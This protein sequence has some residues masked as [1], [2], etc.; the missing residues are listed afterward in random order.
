MIKGNKSVSGSWNFGPRSDEVRSVSDVTQEAIA[1][2][3]SGSV[4]LDNNRDHPHEATLLQLDCSKAQA[5]LNWSPQWDFVTTMHETVTWYK[6]VYNGLNSID[7][8]QQHLLKYEGF[9]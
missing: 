8:T 1:I 6:S 9:T 5:E 4:T 2:W 7:V 3:G